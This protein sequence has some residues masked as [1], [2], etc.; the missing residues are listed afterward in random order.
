MNKEER[1]E[2]GRENYLQPANAKSALSLNV[3]CAKPLNIIDA[4]G[5]FFFYRPG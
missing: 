2:G 5:L 4:F 3:S 1:E